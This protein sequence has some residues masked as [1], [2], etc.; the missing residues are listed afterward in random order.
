LLTFF[1]EA[2]GDVVDVMCC[3]GLAT[4]INTNIVAGLGDGAP[5]PDLRIA[6]SIRYAPQ[7]QLPGAI[8]CIG[9]GLLAA[10]ECV[11]FIVSGLRGDKD[12]SFFMNY[13]TEFTN[14]P[15]D[16]TNH[17]LLYTYILSIHAVDISEHLVSFCQDQ[18]EGTSDRVW[19]I[20]YK[21]DFPD[22]W[23]LWSGFSS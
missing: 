10:R 15:V 21:I 3:R 2:L 11:E 4:R 13:I 7:V 19:S 17:C 12:F 9:S 23:G 8:R 1:G 18:M 20:K 16:C 5:T 14:L 22:G 6:I